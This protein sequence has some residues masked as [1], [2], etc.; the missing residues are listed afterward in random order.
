MVIFVLA[1]MS[2]PGVLAVRRFVIPLANLL[3]VVGI[4]VLL[5]TGHMQSAVAWVVKAVHPHR[6]VVVSP[7]DCVASWAVTPMVGHFTVVVETTRTVMSVRE[8]RR[9]VLP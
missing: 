5:K 4:A 9:A 3:A 1:V 7:D 2:L 6:T 8:R